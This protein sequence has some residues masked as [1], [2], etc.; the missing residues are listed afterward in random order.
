MNGGTRLAVLWN[1]GPNENAL[2]SGDVFFQ[3]SEDRRKIENIGFGTSGHPLGY[4]AGQALLGRL[5]R[6]QAERLNVG[7][8]G[9]GTNRILA[10]D[11]S[12]LPEVLSNL[13][14]NPDLFAEYVR[15]VKEIFPQ[16][17][18]IT[19]SAATG[20]QVEIRVW[21]L[22]PETRRYDLAF[23][24]NQCGTGIG[25]VLAMLYVVIA[26]EDP[27]II[28]IDEP[29]SFL[30]PGAA[31]ALINLLRQFPQHQ[32]VIATHAPEVIAEAGNCPVLQVQWSDGESHGEVHPVRDTD[33]SRQLLVDL[34]ARLSDVFGFDEVLWV[35]GPSDQACLKL[36]LETQ[37]EPKRG[38]AIL[39]VRDTGNFDRRKARDIVS[40]YR[41]ASMVSALVPPTIGFLLDREHR[42]DRD[43]E[44]VQ[45]DTRGAVSFLDRIMLESYLIYP[46]AIIKVLRTELPNQDLRATDADVEAWIRANGK[47]QRYE[48]ADCEPLSQA[49]REKV[50]GA[51]LLQD[52]FWEF[53]EQR[54]EFRKTTHCEALTRE[55]LRQDR[56]FLEPL[57]RILELKV[58]CTRKR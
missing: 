4:I 34:G 28:L 17:E 58:G 38:L 3:P 35:E 44:Q 19:A 1:G 27:Q 32:Y 45:T 48:A 6:F 26:S 2:D 20:N 14:A 12:N 57:T 33:V 5:F 49:W 11:A 37:F 55:I 47:V 53:S 18:A 40:I 29:N 13:Q 56:D 46:P 16:V 52:L 25:Q 22:P 23:P 39:P 24:L 43:I 9:S 7:V 10:P 50:N 15:R 41:Q 21:Q 51:K 8:C 54:G 30:H 42:S 36:I 31:R